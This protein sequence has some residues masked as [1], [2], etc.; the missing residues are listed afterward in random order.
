MIAVPTML[1][2]RLVIDFT[3]VSRI[4]RGLQEIVHQVD[5]VVQEVVVSF[6]NVDM[7]LARELRPELGP[8]TLQDVPEIVIPSPE[9]G[10]GAIDL[11]SQLVPDRFR[12]TVAA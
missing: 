1:R 9:L 5:R 3:T 10:D 12:I 11:S 2:A 8:I 6:S 4:L 7:N